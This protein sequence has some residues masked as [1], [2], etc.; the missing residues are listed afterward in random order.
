MPITLQ[1]ERFISA[2]A[3]RM[4]AVAYDRWLDGS[5]LLTGTPTV[6]EVSY[7]TTDPDTETASTDLTLANKAV[8]AAALTIND[9]TVAIGKAVQFSVA[10]PSTKAGYNYR[11]R[12]TGTT[13]GSPAQLEPIDVILRVV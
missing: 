5:E 13:N 10:V 4:V 6:V 8:N 3:T 7:W 1:E 12:V 11:V 2:G 9:R